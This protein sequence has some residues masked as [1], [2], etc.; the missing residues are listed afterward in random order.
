MYTGGGT[1]ASQA[2]PTPPPMQKWPE[3]LVPPL[4]EREFTAESLR[5]GVLAVK[6]GMTQ[7]WDS[8]GAVLP[9]TMLWIDDCVVSAGST[10]H[11]WC[12]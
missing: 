11:S 3:R 6:V 4:E 10:G 9:L 7:D 2:S 5:T 12:G 1:P 8:H